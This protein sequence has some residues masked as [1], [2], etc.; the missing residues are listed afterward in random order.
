MVIPE[1]LRH[2]DFE[3][4]GVGVSN[5]DKVGKDVGDICGIGP[6]G[7]NADELIAV[8]PTRWSTAAHADVNTRDIGAFLRDDRCVLHRHDAVGLGPP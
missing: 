4:A 8:D 3:L 5:P 2:P 1:V 6:I 7:L